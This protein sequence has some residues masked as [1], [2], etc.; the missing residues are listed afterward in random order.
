MTEREPICTKSI[1]SGLHPSV[2]M[3]RTSITDGMQQVLQAAVSVQVDSASRK[4]APAFDV[5]RDLV[6]TEVE[7]VPEVDLQDLYARQD[8]ALLQEVERGEVCVDDIGEED[9]LHQVVLLGSSHLSDLRRLTEKQLKDQDAY[10]LSQMSM[11]GVLHAYGQHEVV[12]PVFV[13]GIGD[14]SAIPRFNSQIGTTQG[15]QRIPIQQEASQ[16][17]LYQHPQ[18]GVA[19]FRWA[20]A[21]GRIGSFYHLTSY[22][23]IRGADSQQLQEW[24]VQN[25]EATCEADA[26]FY[27][28]YSPKTILPEDIAAYVR[29]VRPQREGY[30]WVIHTPSGAV[31]PGELFEDASS[32][33]D[34][35]E[36]THRTYEDLRNGGMADLLLANAGATGWTGIGHTKVIAAKCAKAGARVRIVYPAR[37]Q[38]YYDASSMEDNF[39][40]QTTALAYELRS[41]AAAH[42]MDR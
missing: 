34:I 31:S 2:S 37:E 19:Y 20:Q 15:L 21:Q 13:E 35:M 7:P 8:S 40:E 16:N 33:I 38:E 1:V 27:K 18:L 25:G 22:P 10:R 23:Y 12:S 39:I 26:A 42:L 17:L 24:S 14:T 9:S 4:T 11:H 5:A 36:Q 29:S 3:H 28:K 30:E 6:I 41:I 32:Y